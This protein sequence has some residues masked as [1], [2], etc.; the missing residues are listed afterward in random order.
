M[1]RM[2]KVQC[3]ECQKE[4]SNKYDL[5]KHVQIH[6]EK[7]H[8]CPECHKM[9]A[10][11]AYVKKHIDFKHVR[12]MRFQCEVCA[13]EFQLAHQL[14]N[15]VRVHT[16]EKPFVCR[17]C[18]HAFA[19]E[20]NLIIHERIHT[21]DKPHA[22]TV[23]SNVAFAQSG[24]LKVHMRTHTGER[25][26]QCTQCEY[27]APT[28]GTLKTHVERN[29]TP[30]ALK[31]KKVQETKVEKLLQEQ[32]PELFVREHKIDHK[33][34]KS[35]TSHSRVDFLFPNHGRRCVVLEVDEYQHD[36]EPQMCET[37]RMNNIVS[38]WRLGG[39]YSPVAFIR[40]NPHAFK[41]DGQTKK[42]TTVERH[43]KLTELIDRLKVQEP[44][45]DVQVYYMFYDT[46]DGVPNVLSDS[47]YYE[48]VKE[49]FVEAIV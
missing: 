40:Y 3:P 2:A 4:F 24:A 16:G 26:F 12:T 8:E 27:A 44:A 18:D 49:W 15:H 48:T 32:Y 35:A 23:C 31:L 17:F 29:H 43:Q 28:S 39:N 11:K 13:M 7:T 46:T 6:G 42:T 19:R 45:Q 21:G 22:C 37:S 25:P 20:A 33:C 34:L 38:S 36:R 47:D 5:A 10:T 14:E 9:F 30:Q 41:V 1:V